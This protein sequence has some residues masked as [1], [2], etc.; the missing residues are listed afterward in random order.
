MRLI[1]LIGTPLATCALAGPPTYDA[2]VIGPPDEFASARPRAM[3]PGGLVVGEASPF[4][5]QYPIRAIFSE[6]GGPAEVLALASEIPDVAYDAND[7]GV[8]AGISSFQAV[9]WVEGEPKI[10]GTEFFDLDG[11]FQ[12]GFFGW[13][14]GINAS[15]MIVGNVDLGL[16][17]QTQ[18]VYWPSAGDAPVMLDGIGD[19]YSY[20]TAIDV[21]DAEMIVGA[22][23][24]T[25]GGIFFP[26]IW[27]SPD[28]EA[29]V[30]EPPAGFIN[31][32]AVAINEAGDVVGRF[33]GGG[34]TEPYLY[35]MATG[36]LEMLGHLDGAD[37][38]FAEARDVNEAQHVVGSSNAGPG[39]AYA[40]LWI[41]GQMHDL[42]DLVEPID[43]VMHLSDAVTIL[44]DGRI[45]AEGLVDDTPG[46]ILETMVVLTPQQSCEADVN[47]D[48]ELNILDFVAFQALFVAGDDAADCD[49][50]G[51]LDI[52]DFVCFQQLFQAGCA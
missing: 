44:D 35:N 10:L 27:T 18:C 17:N 29:L 31:G 1:V 37:M 9:A 13:A 36:T 26:G 24:E 41:E 38:L 2:T 51:S 7:D 43:G 3:T 22:V 34:V 49:R 11:N 50:S 23:Q 40:F 16:L 8:I 12:I 5:D 45:L 42:N 30:L 32:E 46:Q 4:A 52:L 48:G 25:V 15:G 39:V 47:G 20:G 21:N 6:G 14:A 33:S 19:P 28:A